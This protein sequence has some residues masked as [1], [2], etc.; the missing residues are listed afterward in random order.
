MV[1]NMS[2]TSLRSSSVISC[3]GV[4]LCRRTGSPRTRMS[5]T[6]TGRRSLLG[7]RRRSRS[8]DDARDLA[9]LDDEARLGGLDGDVI[10]QRPRGGALARHDLLDVNHLA[11]DPAEGDDL[12]AALDRAQRLLVLSL[13]L[14]LRTDEKEVEDR[15]DQR[16][17][18]QKR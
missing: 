8:A 5:R 6:L 2:A 11:D 12:I 16:H 14:L 1:S 3:T 13:L 4:V 9:A 10:I 17:L 15:E 18:D 7:G